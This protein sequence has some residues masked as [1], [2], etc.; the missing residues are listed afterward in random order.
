MKN[1]QS[2]LKKEMDLQKFLFRQRLQTTAILAL[3]KGRQCLI[4]DK[5]S[6]L[7]LHE[8]SGVTNESSSDDELNLITKEASNN[9]NFKKMIKSSDKVDKNLIDQYLI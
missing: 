9:Y 4:I 3:L 7:V 5:M 6:E 2:F 8:S 1:S